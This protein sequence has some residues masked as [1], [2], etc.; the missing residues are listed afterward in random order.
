MFQ[1]CFVNLYDVH[2]LRLRPQPA[3]TRNVTNYMDTVRIMDRNTNPKNIY[4]NTG[5]PH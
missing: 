3:M 1:T 2:V 5:V 4:H